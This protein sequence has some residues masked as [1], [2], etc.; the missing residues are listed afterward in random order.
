[1]GAFCQCQLEGEKK[2][3]KIN[4]SDQNKSDSNRHEISTKSNTLT[5]TEAWDE[6]FG[7]KISKDRLYAEIRAKRLPHSRIGSRILLRRDSLE[8]WFIQ[9]ESSNSTI[10]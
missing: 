5:F 1:M 2:V 3:E 8:A 4:D 6:I 7:R 9:Q 10:N